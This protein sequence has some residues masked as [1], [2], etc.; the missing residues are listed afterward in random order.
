[1]RNHPFFAVL[2]GVC[3]LIC[4]GVGG[5]LLAPSFA[6]GLQASA[7]V[8][9]LFPFDGV[10]LSLMGVVLGYNSIQGIVTSVRELKEMN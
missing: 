2:S 5:T 4:F 9:K 8:S 1:M 7:F 3:S 10:L 6:S